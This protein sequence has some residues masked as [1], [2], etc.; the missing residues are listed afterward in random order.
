MG[1]GPGGGCSTTCWSSSSEDEAATGPGLRR[2]GAG[3]GGFFGLGLTLTFCFVLTYSLMKSS[4]FLINSSL[5][6][7]FL[8]PS[9]RFVHDES[10]PVETNPFSG[11]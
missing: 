11:S 4:L 1:K 8:S 5:I 7:S 6:P 10:T 9:R 3:G 2:A